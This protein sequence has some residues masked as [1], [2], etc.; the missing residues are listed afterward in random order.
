MAPKAK[1]KP[2]PS[3]PASQPPPPIEDLF[4]TLNR[5]IQN[6]AFQNAVKVA[7]QSS[8]SLDFLDFLYSDP[9]SLI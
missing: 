7:D 8:S 5:H 2:K 1:D 4:T 9:L 6:S 3:S